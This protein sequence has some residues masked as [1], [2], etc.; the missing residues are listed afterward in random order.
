M[1][2]ISAIFGKNNSE[3]NNIYNLVKEQTHRGPDNN[4]IK[5]INSNLIK[6]TENKILLR[7]IANNYSLRGKGHINSPQTEWMYKKSMINYINKMISDSPIFDKYYDRRSTLKFI[8]HFY[9][10]KQKN[11]FKLWQIINLDLWLRNSF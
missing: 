6:K 9:S 2:G 3:F 4:K 7:K 10:A 8:D 11:S 1:C 5:K